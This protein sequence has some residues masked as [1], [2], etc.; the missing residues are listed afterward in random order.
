[1]EKTKLRKNSKKKKAGNYPG[2]RL[3]VSRVH[4]IERVV[5]QKQQKPFC[6]IPERHSSNYAFVLGFGN[7]RVQC[8]GGGMLTMNERDNN[9]KCINKIRRR[10]YR[11]ENKMKG[12]GTVFTLCILVPMVTM[13]I[14]VEH[15][16][17]APARARTQK[18]LLDPCVVRMP[19]VNGLS[20]SGERKN[21]V[22]RK[23]MLNAR[24][25]VTRKSSLS[26]TS[27]SGRAG[28]NFDAATLPKAYSD[29][30]TLPLFA[31]CCLVKG[32]PGTM[33]S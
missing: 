9:S 22:H 12:I 27:W 31:V 29:A 2:R 16:L 26:R 10:K 30:T 3:V 11:Q 28:C 7:E 20:A 1:M 5:S 21:C 19:R 4:T 33:N 8:S 23:K 18:S 32:T 25:N 13:I 15:A 17:Q 24:H 6:R 14:I